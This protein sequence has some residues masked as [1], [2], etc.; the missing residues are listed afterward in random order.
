MDERAIVLTDKFLYK[1]DPKKSFH[2][3]KTG[4]PIDEITS[5]SVTSGR[6]QLI[7][8]HLVSNHDLVFYMHTKTDRVGEFVGYMAKLKRRTYVFSLRT[9]Q[10]NFRHILFSLHSSSSNFTVDIQRYVSAQLGKNKYVIN[11][12]QGDGNK[13]E[14][15]KGSNNNISLL[16][17]NSV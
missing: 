16:L 6:E 11:S 14:F 15:R 7:V 3:R 10:R 17:P 4:I 2:V 12:I 13:V 9:R 5:L 8:V 1:L